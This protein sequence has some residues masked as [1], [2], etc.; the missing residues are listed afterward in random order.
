MHQ[1]VLGIFSHD[2]LRGMSQQDAAQA[3]NRLEINRSQLALGEKLGHGEFGVVYKAQFTSLSGME[4]V[5]AVK[6]L[7]SSGVSDSENEKFLLEARLMAVL[8]HPNIVQLLAVCVKTQPFSAVLEFMPGGD[9]RSFLRRKAG[10]NDGGASASA[11]ASAAAASNS[12]T[13]AASRTHTAVTANTVNDL[14]TL[15]LVNVGLQISSALVYLKDKQVVHR[16]LAARNVL[17]GD[18]IATVKLADFGMS[19]AMDEKDYYMR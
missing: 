3:F 13:A 9:L 1:R 11:S 6:Q 14:T 5:V 18:S 12:M 19:R 8:N 2:F 7:H 16:D 10:L 17:V 4:R 15:D